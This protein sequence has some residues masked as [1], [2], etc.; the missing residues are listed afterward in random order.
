MSDGRELARLDAGTGGHGATDVDD[1]RRADVEFARRWPDTA[2]L[3]K[4]RLYAPPHTSRHEWATDLLPGRQR[5]GLTAPDCL[6]QL[7]RTIS[8]DQV[9]ERSR[10][11]AGIDAISDEEQAGAMIPQ[12]AED[13]EKVVHRSARQVAGSGDRDLID[14]IKRAE[15][16]VPSEIAS[17]ASTGFEVIRD[18]RHDDVATG[19]DRLRQAD[20]EFTGSLGWMGLIR[21]IDD[22]SALHGERVTTELGFVEFVPIGIYGLGNVLGQLR[23]GPPGDYPPGRPP[24]AYRTRSCRRP[25]LMA[26]VLG[27]SRRFLEHSS[28][29]WRVN[30]ATTGVGIGLP[31]PV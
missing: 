29:H 3:D 7:G 26:G 27:A 25:P 1:A 11:T 4:R 8:R 24:G 13:F 15:Q 28:G 23:P 22:G 10:A 30:R 6:R 19:L 31:K 17:P 2:I 12:N 16:A 20:G 9:E 18:G 5:L 14:A 21:D